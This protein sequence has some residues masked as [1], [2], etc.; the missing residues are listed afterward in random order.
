MRDANAVCA[1]CS[2]RSRYHVPW[3]LLASL[4][5]QSTRRRDRRECRVSGVWLCSIVLK[6]HLDGWHLTDA[7]VNYFHHFR[8]RGTIR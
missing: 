7:L 3:H 8:L 4:S 1:L 5:D 2:R 6:D